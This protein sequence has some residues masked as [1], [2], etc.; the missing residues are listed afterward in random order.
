MIHLAPAGCLP[1]SGFSILSRSIA[2]SSSLLHHFTSKGPSQETEPSSEAP[3]WCENIS[4]SLSRVLNNTVNIVLVFLDDP[5]VGAMNRSMSWPELPRS[6]KLSRETVSRVSSTTSKPTKARSKSHGHTTL[7]S[8]RVCL[9]RF[10]DFKPTPSSASDTVETAPEGPVRAQPVPWA[11]SN[12]SKHSLS[13]PPANITAQIP[14]ATTGGETIVAELGEPQSTPCSV[15]EVKTLRMKTSTPVINQDCDRILHSFPP[16]PSVVAPLPLTQGSEE[17]EVTVPSTPIPSSGGSCGAPSTE[18]APQRRPRG[19][20]TRYFLSSEKRT[21]PKGFKQLQNKAGT[22]TP[23]HKPVYSL[24]DGFSE[25]EAIPTGLVQMGVRRKPSLP[26]VALGQLELT[27]T[28]NTEPEKKQKMRRFM[29]TRKRNRAEDDPFDFADVQLTPRTVK[30][31]KR[32]DLSDR[33]IPE[34][35]PGRSG[36]P[37]L[38]EVDEKEDGQDGDPPQAVGTDLCENTFGNVEMSSPRKPPLSD[39]AATDRTIPATLVARQEETMAPLMGLSAEAW[40]TYEVS[41]TPVV[42]ETQ[43]SVFS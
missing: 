16:A 38:G 34:S 27:Q 35:P 15:L 33:V 36:S 13:N 37:I 23:D 28:T 8:Q 40:G 14:T 26:S 25:Y 31:P 5:G 24:G 42:F 29:R 21:T 20:A 9:D 18:H 43:L 17:Q 30:R 6:H 4:S 3:E 41:Q 12:A 10:N 11:P 32:K 7:S 2:V 22:V 19:D 39:Q 1:S